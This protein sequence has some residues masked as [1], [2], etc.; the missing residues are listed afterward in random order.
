MHR[1]FEQGRRVFVSK[2]IN[3]FGLETQSNLSL[4]FGGGIG[5][6]PMI[7]FAH[8]LDHAGRDFKMMYSA[9]RLDSAAFDDDFAA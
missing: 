3:H 2:P 8:E 7:A 6:T 5:V 9:S 1:I 4:L